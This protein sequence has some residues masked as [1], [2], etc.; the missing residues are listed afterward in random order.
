[1]PKILIVEDDVTTNNLISDYLTDAGHAVLS[2]CD[3]MKALEIFAQESIELVI[4]DIMLPNM[5]GLQVLNEI[6][7]TS[8]MPVLMLTALSDEETQI[9]SFDSLA[10]D[11]M[12]KPFS[13]VLLGKRVLALLRRTGKIEEKDIWKYGNIS[14]DFSGYVAEKDG[15]PV[16]LAPKEIQLLKLLI[17]NTGRVMTR[18]KLIDGVWGMDAPL[19]DRTIDTY[20][21][22]IRQKLDLNCITTVKG[23]GYRFEVSL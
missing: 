9:T 20:I 2:A 18:E 11:Y 12:T 6:R 8:D 21:R 5:S 3:G 17:K 19:Y 10:D 14:V 4:L 23:V 15:E 7:K 22:R 16:E 13:I 1:M